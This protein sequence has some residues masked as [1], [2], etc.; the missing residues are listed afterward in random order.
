MVGDGDCVV[1]D[2]VVGDS[3]VGDCVVGDCVVGAA[4][5]SAAV[6]NVLGE[7]GARNVKVTSYFNATAVV[8][9]SACLH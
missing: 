3:V 6:I 9:K 1:G 8:T 7:P 4:V 2:S 5:V